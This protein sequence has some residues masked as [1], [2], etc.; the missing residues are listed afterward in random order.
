MEAYE[1]YHRTHSLGDAERLAA[2]ATRRIEV[3]GRTTKPYICVYLIRI[4][5]RIYIFA[6]ECTHPKR[7][8]RRDDPDP[9][10]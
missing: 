1:G 10:L 9:P 8:R 5:L 6:A 4:H 2:M 7:G 3:M